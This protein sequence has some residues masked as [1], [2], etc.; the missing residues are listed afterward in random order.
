MLIEAKLYQS[1]KDIDSN[2]PTATIEIEVPQ[3][4]LQAAY[5]VHNVL[6]LMP[7]AINEATLSDI[8]IARDVP[9]KLSDETVRHAAVSLIVTAYTIRLGAFTQSEK[10]SDALIF[11]NDINLTKY[12]YEEQEQTMVLGPWKIVA[13]RETSG[14]LTVEVFENGLE[15]GPLAI[16]YGDADSLQGDEEEED[17][18]GS[19]EE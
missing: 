16:C 3:A 13:S 17:D 2:A 11:F 1:L 15:D 18:E 7:L 14:D 4:M 9:I 19:D 5:A 8:R 6:A 10:H 12:C